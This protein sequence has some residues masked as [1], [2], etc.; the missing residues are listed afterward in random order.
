MARHVAVIGA[1]ISGIGAAK[2]LQQHG[3]EVTVYEKSSSVGGVWAFGYLDVN[4]QSHDFQYRYS[5]FPWPIKCD[6]HPT[7][8][9]VLYYL[10]LSVQHYRINVL[11]NHSVVSME[12][13]ANGWLVHVMNGD[14]QIVKYYDY[15]IISSGLFTDGKYRPVY[16]GQEDFI[17]EI[18]TEREIESLAQFSNKR[19][20]VV[21]YG[22]SALDMATLSAEKSLQT[23]H[24][25][26]HARWTLP[27]N[28][29]GLNPSYI[30]YSRMGTTL[31]PCW[32]Q[33]S[34]LAKYLHKFAFIIRFIWS[35]IGWFLNFRSSSFSF[36]QGE[37]AAKRIKTTQPHLPI[38]HDKRFISAMMPSSYYPL[39][40]KNKITPVLSQLA[41]FTP[42]GIKLANGEFLKC[43]AVIFSMGNQ[44]PEFPFLPFKYRCMVEKEGGVQL[45]RHLI[46]PRINNVGFLGFNHCALHIPAVEVGTIWLIAQWRNNLTLPTIEVTVNTQSFSIYFHDVF[47]RR[48]KIL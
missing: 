7:A 23:Y 26:R 4:I 37:I 14:R 44:T 47:F 16:P 33:P 25:F 8:R 40:V 12:E 17:G 48:W 45:Y 46:H 18:M 34:A 35:C 15:V 11:L 38:M 10:N 21:G 5:D 9:Q 13:K 32:V 20:A 24:I 31:I 36:W 30:L 28:A 42:D 3:Y 2:V 1:G 41:G 22:R 39:V 43:D 19:V 29:F 6:E 27:E